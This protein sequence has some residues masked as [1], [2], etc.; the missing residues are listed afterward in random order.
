MHITISH[1]ISQLEILAHPSLQENYDNAGLMCGD[2]EMEC[3]GVLC[4]LDVTEQV[5]EEAIH[6]ELNLVVA[7]HPVIFKPIRNINPYTENGRI[8]TLAIKNDIAIYCIHTNLDNVWDGVNFALAKKLGFPLDSLKILAPVKHKIAKLYTYVPLADSEKVANALFEAGAGH[9]GKYAECSYS[10]AGIGTFRPQTGSNPVIGDAGGPREKVA[11]NRLEVVFP[12]WKQKQVLQALKAAHP[13]EEVAY[14]SII[15]E[16]EHQ[17]IGAGMMA[18]L[19][20]A[21][22]VGE[23]LKHIQQSLGIPVIRHTRF[24]DKLIKK[25]ALCGGAGAFL[26]K[27]AIV[28]GADAY[29]TGDLKYH[30]FFE[31][32]GKLLLADIG[33][34]ESEQAAVA[35]LADVLQNKFPTFAVLQTKISTNPVQYFAG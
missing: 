23:F 28:A 7:H 26:M 27:N 13:Y 6:L 24:P 8:L 10:A 21:M 31:T 35:L 9:I 5:I 12:I 25:V 30:D 18:I 3:K 15:T 14:E 16:N 2:I 33:H 29:L 20:T 11:E 17:E 34:G 19:D 1:I 32:E 22:E 4:S